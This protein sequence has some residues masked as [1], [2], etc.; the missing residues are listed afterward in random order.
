MDANEVS[1]HVEQPPPHNATRKRSAGAETAGGVGRGQRGRAAT[2]GGRG[3]RGRG[4]TTKGRTKGA[5]AAK[6]DAH[7]VENL[8]GTD[9]NHDGEAASDAGTGA[10]SSM[11]ADLDEETHHVNNNNTNNSN[12]IHPPVSQSQVQNQPSAHSA[13]SPSFVSSLP[14]YPASPINSPPPV[15]PLNF[16]VPQQNALSIKKK[17]VAPRGRG[18]RLKGVNGAAGTVGEETMEMGTAPVSFEGTYHTIP[19][20]HKLSV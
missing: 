16:S 20:P 17:P 9:N 11:E 14:T 7:S 12:S 5:V 18:E 4:S 1:W 8:N 15:L 3:A 6:K 10:D 2:R 13:S 19:H